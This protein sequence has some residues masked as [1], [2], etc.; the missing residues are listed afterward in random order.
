MKNRF[1]KLEM[2]SSKFE[3]KTANPR[4]QSKSQVEDTARVTAQQFERV[5][6]NTKP[7]E[8]VRFERVMQKPTPVET[9]KPKLDISEFPKFKKEPIERE[10]NTSLEE[11]LNFIFS[12]SSVDPASLFDDGYELQDQAIIPNENLDGTFI[13]EENQIEFFIYDIDK[14]LLFSDY[15]F[16]DWNI[17]TNTSTKT[18]KSTDTIQLYPAKNLYDR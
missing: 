10:F 16:E 11:E 2:S 5:I 6:Q 4:L 13:P 15:K 7:T 14:N 3:R 17:T 1:D 12:Q 18:L 8:E 9:L